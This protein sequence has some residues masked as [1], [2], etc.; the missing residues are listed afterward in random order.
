MEF[1]KAATG[2]LFKLS[3]G[4]AWEGALE[5]L[6]QLQAH[7]CRLDAVI[8][9]ALCGAFQAS[10]RWELMLS[11]LSIHEALTLDTP[12]CTALLKLYGRCS[13][14]RRAL[15]IFEGMLSQGPAPDAFVPWKLLNASLMFTVCY[16]DNN[17]IKY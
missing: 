15:R 5:I 4:G 2:R 11:L 17:M 12:A 6:D 10:G 8:C 3:H 13:E 16:I 9:S 1:A 14:W 7:R